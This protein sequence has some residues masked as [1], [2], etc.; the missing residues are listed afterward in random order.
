MT[1]KHED[2][3]QGPREKVD[4]RVAA[5]ETLARLTSEE[6]PRDGEIPRYQI[7]PGDPAG[8]IYTMS[9]GRC[10]FLEPHG[11]WSEC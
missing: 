2:L 6:P 5:R 9:D 4:H 7:L 1:E 10:F 11:G 8:I 3:A